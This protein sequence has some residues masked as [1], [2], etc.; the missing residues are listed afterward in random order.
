VAS[1]GGVAPA[2]RTLEAR[3]TEGLGATGLPNAVCVRNRA[4]NAESV[5][6]QLRVCKRQ[7]SG[8]QYRM[9]PW[10]RSRETERASFVQHS[11]RCWTLMKQRNQRV[12]I[13]GLS[14]ERAPNVIRRVVE[15]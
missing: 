5:G 13:N 9:T 14:A 3:P 15:S 11:I 10:P 2:W 6:R 7:L 4:K 8:L 1:S 12:Q